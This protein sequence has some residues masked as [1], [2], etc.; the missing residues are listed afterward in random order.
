MFFAIFLESLTAVLPRATGEQAGC[1]NS[2]LSLNQ[3][4][5]GHKSD[6]APGGEIRETGLEN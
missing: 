6:E 5:W 2:F 3:V 4:R 1:E